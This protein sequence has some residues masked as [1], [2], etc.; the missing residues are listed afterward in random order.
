MLRFYYSFIYI[1]FMAFYFLLLGEKTIKM[2]MIPHHYYK[3][4]S[5]MIL[6]VAFGLSAT[7]QTKLFEDQELNTVHNYRISQDHDGYIWMI[8]EKGITKYDGNNARIFTTNDGLPT[9]DIWNFRITDDNKIWFFSSAKEH[10][11]IY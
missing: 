8:G 3:T 4:I 6:S 11:Y 2:N 1:F 5:L 7:A 10:G 9:N